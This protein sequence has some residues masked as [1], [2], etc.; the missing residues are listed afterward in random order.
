MRRIDVGRLVI[1]VGACG[2][3]NSCASRSL[4]RLCVPSFAGP[5]RAGD[6][7][8]GAGGSLRGSA[9]SRN[10]RV[11]TAPGSLSVFTGPGRRR[12]GSPHVLRHGLVYLGRPCARRPGGRRA[13]RPRPPRSRGRSSTRIGGTHR[14]RPG[15]TPTDR[16]R[17]PITEPVAPPEYAQPTLTRASRAALVHRDRSDKPTDAGPKLS[18]RTQQSGLRPS[19]RRAASPPPRRRHERP[20]STFRQACS[21]TPRSSGH[22]RTDGWS[23]AGCGRSPAP[24]GQRFRGAAGPPGVPMA[25]PRTGGQEIAGVS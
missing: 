7:R 16:D 19:A 9:G 5:S 10:I 1:S 23:P 4:R 25:R 2:R 22:R 17:A 8:R 14:P 20:I 13:A 15:P 3:A 11:R 12:H 24:V 21:G 6:K 18:P